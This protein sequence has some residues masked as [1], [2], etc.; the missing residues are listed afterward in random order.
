VSD[1]FISSDPIAW[2]NSYWK[3]LHDENSFFRS[4]HTV[5]DTAV[6]LQAIAGYDANDTNSSRSSTADYRMVLRRP[7]SALRPGVAREF[8]FDDLDPEFQVAIDNALTA[9]R[10]IT[11]AVRDVQLPS[12]AA[13]QERVRAIVRGAEAF[14]YHAE[15]VR[16]VSQRYLPETLVKVRTGGAVTTGD[17]IKARQDVAESR[18]AIEPRPERVG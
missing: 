3:R 13:G 6:M 16:T 7:T 18:R 2:L 14:E 17:Y 9:L 8:F 15:F 11:A 10:G 12:P 1:P 4:S 5:E